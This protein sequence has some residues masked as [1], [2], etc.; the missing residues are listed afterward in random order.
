MR[1][2]CKFGT[3]EDGEGPKLTEIC[4]ETNHIADF[5]VQKSQRPQLGESPVLFLGKLSV[6]SK[7]SFSKKKESGREMEDS[8]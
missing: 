4:H 7:Q 3:S 2:P 5:P 8:F 1:K 6:S